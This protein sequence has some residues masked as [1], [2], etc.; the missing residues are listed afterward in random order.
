MS[1]VLGVSQG[2]DLWHDAGDVLKFKCIDSAVGSEC[3]AK[4]VHADRQVILHV[5]SIDRSAYLPLVPPID[6]NFDGFCASADHTYQRCVVL[7][8]LINDL[9]E[10]LS[11]DC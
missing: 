8:Y 9:S 10:V 6:D 5:E 2:D 1:L 7:R 3:R 4:D 11:V